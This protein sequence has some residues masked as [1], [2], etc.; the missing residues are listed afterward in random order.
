MPS[1]P[2]S[3]DEIRAFL[4][5]EPPRIAK[6]ATVRADGRPHVAPVWAVL[7]PTAADDASPVGDLVFNTGRTTVKGANLLRDPRV[8]LSYD[9]ER[10]PF[11]FVVIDGIATV[12]QDPEELLRSATV[13]GGRFMGQDRA[14]EY[15]RRNAVPGELVV[16]VRP[17][18][19][20]AVAGVAD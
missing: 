19:I 10:R 15:G 7:D 1:H 3:T 8:A 12:S 20:T 16:R 14:E 17:T 18:H 11:S 5:A 9:D 4:E 13:I 6:L 2:M